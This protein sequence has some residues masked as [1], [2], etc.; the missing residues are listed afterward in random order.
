MAKTIMQGDTKKNMIDSEFVGSLKPMTN[1]RQTLAQAN[2]DSMLTRKT[3]DRHRKKGM[4]QTN[5]NRLLNEHTTHVTDKIHI[6]VAS[7]LLP[8]ITNITESTVFWTKWETSARECAR[9][10]ILVS[11]VGSC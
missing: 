6:L 7:C 3:L 9:A 10:Q 4:N 11:S 5:M 1:R 2:S 8:K